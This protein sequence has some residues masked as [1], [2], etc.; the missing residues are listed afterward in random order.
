MKNLLTRESNFRGILLITVLIITLY[1]SI[2]MDGPSAQQVT[3]PL[4]V[5]LDELEWGPP[6]GGNGSPLGLRTARQGV[7]PKTGGQT[8]Y[9]MF[10]AGSH[11]DLHWHTY[12]EHVVVVKG[13][14]TIELGDEVYELS[15]GSYIV[16]PGKLNHSWDVPDGGDEAVI[17]VRRAGPADF[18]YVID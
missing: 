9:A 8:Y 13:E 15:T 17:L 7:D 16:I 6:G 14:L 1:L 4:A 18:H 12:D 11:F 3:Q 5:N 2:S 10:P